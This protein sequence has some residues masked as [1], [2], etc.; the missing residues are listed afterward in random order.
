MPHSPKPE[1]MIDA[2][3]GMSAH[4]LRRAPSR[5][6]SCFLAPWRDDINGSMTREELAR[7]VRPS[8]RPIPPCSP[9][10]TGCCAAG[11]ARSQPKTTRSLA[12]PGSRSAATRSSAA[13]RTTPG[14][15]RLA[16]AV[17]SGKEIVYGNRPDWRAFL[18]DRLGDR[19]F[20]RPMRTFDPAALSRE[21]L[22]RLAASPLPEGYALRRLEAGWAEQLD[23][24]LAP[25]ALQVF[26]SPAAFAECGV[27][28]GVVAGN[29]LASAA[30]TYTVSPAS[31]EIAIATRPSHRQRGLA[32]AAAARLLLHC[33]D[34]GLTPHWNASNPV[35][36]RLAQRLG[37]RGRRHLRSPPAPLNGAGALRLQK[38]A[39]MPKRTPRGSIGCVWMSSMPSPARPAAARRRS[40]R[41]RET[42]A[43]NR[44][45][46]SSFRVQP[47]LE[48][49]A[50]LRADERGR[51]RNAR[52]CPRR[53]DAARSSA[54][55][56]CRASRGRSWTAT[57]GRDDA[58]DRPGDAVPGW[59]LVP[60]ARPRPREARVERRA[61]A[62][63]R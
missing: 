20:D 44:L 17:A 7:R 35:S 46:T 5:P 53:A 37:F 59:I 8:S 52:C 45:K 36:I 61:R 4:R 30:T 57:P 43:S 62:A 29:V 39:L 9:S 40:S 54:S 58:L 6:C 56:G 31:T 21:S 55:A 41:C 10:W 49:V 63:A 11:S 18:L 23:G 47:L 48:G 26:A 38:L 27:G 28:Y 33:L 2:P 22:E 34:A 24:E 50:E 32:I 1:T 19:V 12:W 16:G 3:S 13:N 42:F 15:A 14:A 51:P 25:H 60:E